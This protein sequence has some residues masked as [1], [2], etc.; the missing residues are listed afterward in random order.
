MA[1]IELLQLT[2]EYKSNVANKYVIA[3]FEIE[4]CR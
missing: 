1:R 3:A 4:K 2:S